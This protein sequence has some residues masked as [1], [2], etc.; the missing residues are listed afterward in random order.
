VLRV[1]GGGELVCWTSEAPEAVEV[2]DGRRPALALLQR[3]RWP[4]DPVLVGRGAAARQ[5]VRW[6]LV[7]VTAAPVCGQ[8]GG[9]VEGVPGR[10]LSV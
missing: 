3:L 5:Q 8:R 10:P 2:P 9:Y 7:G 6:H 1:V 4:D